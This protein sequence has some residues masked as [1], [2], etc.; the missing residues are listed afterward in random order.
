MSFDGAPFAAPARDPNVDPRDVPHPHPLGMRVWPVALTAVLMLGLLPLGLK[1]IPGAIFAMGVTLFLTALFAFGI[2]KVGAGLVIAGMFFAPMTALTMPGGASFIT[3]SDLLMVVGFGLLF[4]VLVTQP[5]HVPWTFALGAAAF[6][7]VGCVSSLASVFAFGSLNILLRVLAATVILPLLFV[8]WAPR[9][10]RLVSLAGAY[11]LGVVLS[12]AYGLLNGPLPEN[13]RY[14]GLSEQPTAFGY[15]GLLAV[16]FLPFLYQVV[17]PS[18]RWLVLGSGVLCLAVIWF[19]GSRGPLVVVAFL[20]LMYPALERSLKVAGALA[21]GGIFVVA[22]LDRILNDKDGSNALSRLL[23]GSGSRYSNNER[24]EGLANAL[25]VFRH[26]P[27][28][29]GGWDFDVILAHNIYAQV[30]AA[31]G[32]LGLTAFLFIIWSFVAPLFTTPRPYRLLC[33]P[34]LAYVVAGPITPNVGSRYVGVTLAMS[35][36]VASMREAGDPAVV[37]DEARERSTA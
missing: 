12:L 24:K 18:R 14:T 3:A 28:I 7:V 22:N 26:H 16:C 27:L 15:S 31:M 25:E 32:V 23:G 21:F 2:E 9:G 30:V 37:S 19:S 33:Y 20:A 36:V 35:F 10:R 17:R 11:V 29:G 13:N 6:F 8:W 1:S 4:P 5:L 34:A